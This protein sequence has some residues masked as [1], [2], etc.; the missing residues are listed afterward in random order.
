MKIAKNLHIL[1]IKYYKAAVSEMLRDNKKN[2]Y[3]TILDTYICT[4]V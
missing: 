1:I 2:V 4:F 3:L